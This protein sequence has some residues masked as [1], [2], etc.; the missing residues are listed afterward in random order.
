MVTIKTTLTEKFYYKNVQSMI[1]EKTKKN[2][3]GN[4]YKRL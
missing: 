3:D 1:E 4:K 2:V